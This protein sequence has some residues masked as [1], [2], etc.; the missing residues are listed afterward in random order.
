MIIPQGLG[1]WFLGRV[2]VG[3]LSVA[4]VVAATTV[5]YPVAAQDAYTCIDELSEA[6]LD[7]RNEWISESFRKGRAKAVR[8]R[9]GWI[10]AMTAFAAYGFYTGAT[11]ERSIQ[12]DDNPK[13]RRFY[14]Y[15][16]ASASALTVLKL[17][18]VP[19]ADVWG[20]KRIRKMPISTIEEKRAKLRYATK[21]LEKSASGQDFLIGIGNIGGGVLFGAVFGTAYVAKFHNKYNAQSKRKDRALDRAR[22][23]GLFILPTAVAGGLTLTGPSH[24]IVDL[25]SYRGIACSSKYYDNGSGDSDI[26]L[27]LSVSPLN[28]GM[29]LTF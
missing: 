28:F 1:S 9:A 17:V 26:D 6:E 29:K 12:N 21:T 22:A 24:S 2:L 20:H 25:E 23:A 4:I 18:A 5:S 11:G 10:T 15:A 7:Y 13:W 19:M 16:L 27:E 3:L 14:D 8:W